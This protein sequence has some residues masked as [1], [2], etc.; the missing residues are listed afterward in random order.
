MRFF[1]AACAVVPVAACAP[2]YRTEVVGAGNALVTSRSAAGSTAPGAGIQLPR[3]SYDL[4]M[5]FDIPHA[6]II[7]W[8]VSC[9]GVDEHGAVGEAYDAYRTRRL[10]E[11]RARREADRKRMAAVTGAIAGAVAPRVRTETRVVTPSGEV[12]VRR[13]VVTP[14]VVEPPPPV[15]VVVLPDWDTGRGTLGAKIHIDTH[16]DGACAITAAADDTNIRAS[17]QV[18]RIHDLGLEAAERKQASFVGAVAVRGRIAAQLV[19]YGADESA[20]QRRLDAAAHARAEAEARAGAEARARAEAELRVSAEATARAEADARLRLEA[21]ARADAEASARA[22]A[23]ARAGAEARARIE[24]ELRVSTEASERA[25]R[26]RLE[27]EAH[28]RWVAE[29]PARARAELIVRQ[30]TYAYTLRS[31]LVAWLVTECHAD[32]GRRARLELERTERDRVLAIRIEAERVERERL[33]AIRIEAERVERM[34]IE[35]IHQRELAIRLDAERAQVAERDRIRAIHERELAIRLDAERAERARKAALVAELE[36]RRIDGALRIRTQLTGYLV[37]SGA[38]IRPPRPE[39]LAENPGSAPFPGARWTF[40]HWSWTNTQWLWTAGGWSDPDTFGATGGEVAVTRPVYVPE[41]VVTV[42]APPITIVRDAPVRPG[43]T[44]IGDHR[45]DA[46]V[47][48]TPSVRPGAPVIRDHREPIR[49]APAPVVRDQR[50]APA[51][52]PIVRDHRKEDNKV[53]VR[54]HR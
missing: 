41:P 45:N 51:P 26:L 54:D 36:Q 2:R 31:H 5:R 8:R 20:R 4:A 37:A 6:Q 46:P 38:R 12:V 27:A 34:R 21:K 13:E 48:R 11:L 43:V 30:R 3:G 17:F 9:P 16:G 32:A 35:A 42:V 50:R 47:V 10:D 29:A 44:I 23:E 15:D 33:L 53:K 1:L 14:V 25:L 39:A 18:V 28:A 19:T 49:P 22:K 52:A 24:A 7:D 40:G